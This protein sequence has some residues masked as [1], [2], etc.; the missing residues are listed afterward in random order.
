MAFCTKARCH[1]LLA[2]VVVQVVLSWTVHYGATAFQVP[3]RIRAAPASRCQQP[4]ASTLK[5]SSSVATST[6][7]TALSSS[8]LG[9]G[10]ETSVEGWTD[11]ITTIT[12][13]AAQSPSSTIIL[14]EETWR[15]YVPLAVS[16]L[17]IVDILLG[18]PAANSIL[19][20][21][22]AQEDAQ[23]GDD[24]NDKTRRNKVVVQTKGERIDSEQLANAALERA[25]NALE[26]NTE[27]ER[28]KTDADR[29]EDLRKKMDNQLREFDEKKNEKE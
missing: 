2:V 23:E 29:M 14:A 3:H 25:R 4:L 8:L 6:T 13:A 28:L 7:T 9:T 26:W 19:G 16:L 10:M 17:V 15:Q 22:R 18:S 21:V 24:S 1:F 11:M 5:I 20:M 27:K 12:A